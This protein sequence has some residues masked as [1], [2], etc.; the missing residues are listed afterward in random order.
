MLSVKP[1]LTSP[2]GLIHFATATRTKQ[3]GVEKILHIMRNHVCSSKPV[4]IAAMH[5]DSLEEAEK[6]KERIATEFDCAELFI[7]NFSPVIGYATGRG[8]LGSAYYES[9]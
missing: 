1:I 6:L 2:N 4:H 8:T 9:F 5:A 3:S 7:T